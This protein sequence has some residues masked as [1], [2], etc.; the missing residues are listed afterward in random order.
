MKKIE[1]KAIFE[2]FSVEN[3]PSAKRNKHNRAV[4]LYEPFISDTTLAVHFLG[5]FFQPIKPRDFE[6]NEDM[7]FFVTLVF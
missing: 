5:E 2:N 7:K 3:N 1:T 4:K 6:G